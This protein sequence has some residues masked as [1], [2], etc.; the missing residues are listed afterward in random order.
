MMLFLAEWIGVVSTIFNFFGSL[1]AIAVFCML[2]ISNDNNDN[3]R[4]GAA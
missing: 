3:W 1:C 4:G 2:I